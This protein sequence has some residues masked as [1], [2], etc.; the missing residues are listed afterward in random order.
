MKCLSI[1]PKMLYALLFYLCLIN[2]TLTYGW[3]IDI[4]ITTEARPWS[5]YLAVTPMT[6]TSEPCPAMTSPWPCCLCIICSVCWWMFFMDSRLG[7]LWSSCPS[8]TRSSTFSSYIDTRSALLHFSRC[9]VYINFVLFW[10]E[11]FWTCCSF[12]NIQSFAWLAQNNDRHIFI[13]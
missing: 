6:S 5:L 13:T 2:N 1:K 9:V 12:C 4:V 8:L 7:T 3:R 10:M 11:L